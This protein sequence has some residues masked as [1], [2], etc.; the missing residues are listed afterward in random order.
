M[1]DPTVDLTAVIIALGAILLCQLI[2]IV[3][4]LVA[5]NKAKKSV[6]HA[7]VALPMFLTIHFLPVANAELIALGLGVAV[8][9]A[10][11]VLMWLLLSSGM[12]RVFK[13]KRRAHTEQE[14]TAVVR[15]EDLQEEPYAAPDEEPVTDNDEVV[16]EV[17]EEVI[18][19]VIDEVFDELA[20][21]FIEEA[22]EEFIEE[23][24]EEVIE[25]ITE[26]PVEEALD[27]EAFDEELAQELA[28]EEEYAEEEYVNDEY[29]EEVY[30]DEEHADEEY[31]DEEY[32]DEEYAES[33]EEVVEE[34]LLEEVEEVYEDEELTEQETSDD[35][36]STDEEE[37]VYAYDEEEAERV[38]DAQEANQEIEET[39][40]DTDPFAGVFGES[41]RQDGDSSNEGGD[42]WDADAY[43]ESYEYGDETDAPYA[44][45]EDADREET[46][47]QG[48]VDP[49]AYIIED[50][51]EE[52][53]DDEEMY[54]YD[55]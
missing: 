12:I 38:S 32:I 27:E 7:S 54:Q 31:I 20:E 14:I 11:I 2:A 45:T 39:A 4:V 10:Q 3:L 34:T 35:S 28:Q 17:V 44:E 36:Y 48:P 43:G 13:T 41:D 18:D 5:R 47:G 30:A 19:E 9:L 40:Y 46:K 37:N 25:E 1:A 50:D 52:I 26:E 55:E 8:L 22:T 23:A 49:Y 21:E 42:S 24:T 33:T 51:A 6:M 15:E 53:S 29:A 16:D